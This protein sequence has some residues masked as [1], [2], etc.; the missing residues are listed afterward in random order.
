MRVWGD[1]EQLQNIASVS[2]HEAWWEIDFNQ[3]LSLKF[4]RQELVYDDH[5]LLG[6]VGCVHQARSH[7]AVLS[8]SILPELNIRVGIRLCSQLPRWE[9]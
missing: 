7:D 9:F 6:N 3:C 5:R 4:G 1:E 2:A 8:Y